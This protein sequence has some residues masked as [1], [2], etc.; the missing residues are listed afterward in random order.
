MNASL[1]NTSLKNEIG[2][3][4]I[5]ESTRSTSLFFDNSLPTIVIEDIV[6]DD[7]HHSSKRELLVTTLP[8]Y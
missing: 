5:E 8:P 7:A 4:I 1:T 3:Q 2:C 6:F